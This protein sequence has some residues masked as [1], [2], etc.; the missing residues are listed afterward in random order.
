MVLGAD[1]IAAMVIAVIALKEG[2]NAWKG[3]TCCPTPVTAKSV[4]GQDNCDC[5]D[6]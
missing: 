3:D 6:D 4:A 2:I 5:C 1:P